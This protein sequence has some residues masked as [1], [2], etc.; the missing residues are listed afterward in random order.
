MN[1][2]NKLD[3]AMMAVGIGRTDAEEEIS[4]AGL[5][6][7]VVVACVNSPVS[8]TMSGDGPAVTTLLEDLQHRGIF[9]RKLN[10]GGKA[11]HS[12]HMTVL[13]PELE[14]LLPVAEQGLPP[15]KGKLKKATMV[16]SVTAEAKTSN[17]D[18]TYWRTNMENAVLFSPAVEYIANQGDV[19]LLEIGPHSALELPIKQIRSGLKRTEERL[20]YSSSLTRGQNAANCCLSL[21]GRLFLH[22]HPVSFDKINSQDTPLS[23]PR[24]LSNLPAYPRSYDGS[25][26]WS[27]P[28]ISREVRN[29]EVRHHELLGARVPGGDGMT[30]SWRNLLQVKY[31]TWLESHKRDGL[32]IFPPACYIAMA[33]EA[34][35]QAIGVSRDTVNNYSLRN[36]NILDEL[37]LSSENNTEME[38]F[39]TLRPKPLSFATKSKDWW[40][41]EVNSYH[42]GDST[43]HATGSI[44][45]QVKGEQ[46]Q[47]MLP[48]SYTG[49]EKSG[50]NAWYDKLAKQGLNFGPDLRS[51][52]EVYTDCDKTHRYARTVAPLLQTFGSHHD[53]YIIHPITIGALLQSGIIAN[54]AGSVRNLEAKVPVSIES[55]IIRSPEDPQKDSAWLIDSTAGI[56]GF[57]AIETNSEL[58]NRKGQI[59]AQMKNMR[60]APFVA[61]SKRQEKLAQRN[62]MLRVVWKPDPY[63]SCWTTESFSKH[64]DDAKRSNPP[65]LSLPDE[66]RLIFADVLS[67]LTHKNPNLRILE[68]SD[69]TIE[70]SRFVLED[71]SQSIRSYTAGYLSEN[72]E[73]FG[74]DVRVE[75]T[76]AEVSKS[77]SLI[78]DQ[79]YDLIVLPNVSKY[80]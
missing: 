68:L 2:V 63:G 44:S 69:E 12:H 26:L 67:L 10:T 28:R 70:V 54:A 18:A 47:S 78:T 72:G 66:K 71:F 32:V 79:I 56:V 45:V 42:M 53:H 61:P 17:F 58:H 13:G 23:L 5:S 37:E 74:G 14:K 62:P 16:S 38:L 59:V 60:M 55:A 8:V 27:E 64:I 21:L 6:G 77:A 33:I 50:P 35:S 40:D 46:P 7:K 34:V 80:S 19:H 51:I 48:Y 52:K 25:V 24:V 11:Y 65:T 3:G 1:G 73:L 22:G 39:T 41:F 49:L 75:S 20:P 57:G 76:P 30:K 43:T 15:S 36:I 4:K 29:R 9:A 31:L